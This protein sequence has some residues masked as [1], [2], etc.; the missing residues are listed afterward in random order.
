MKI[1][2]WNVNGVKSVYEKGFLKIIEGLKADIFCLQEIKL[3]W[4]H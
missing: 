4:I 2:S 1:I 3:N